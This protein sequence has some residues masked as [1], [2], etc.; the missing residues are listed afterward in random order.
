MAMLGVGNTGVG[1]CRSVGQVPS[2][3][4][5][6]LGEGTRDLWNAFVA[7]QGTEQKALQMGAYAQV[8]AALQAGS[9][10]GGR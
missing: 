5:E 10:E 1:S 7:R 9:G 8:T 6:E 2:C 4:P 3:A